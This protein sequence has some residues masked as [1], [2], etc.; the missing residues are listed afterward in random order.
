[1]RL[2]ISIPYHALA[3]LFQILYGVQYVTKLHVPT[4]IGGQRRSQKVWIRMVNPVVE[5]EADLSQVLDIWEP[6][7]EARLVID[8]PTLIPILLEST[9]LQF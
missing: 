3:G 9:D 8:L 6:T 5:A 2:K 1:M 7:R 4:P